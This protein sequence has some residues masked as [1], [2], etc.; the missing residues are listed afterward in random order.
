MSN[1]PQLDK[2]AL[3]QD[4]LEQIKTSQSLRRCPKCSGELG[5]AMCVAGD[6]VSAWQN[7]STSAKRF[8]F[9]SCSGCLITWSLELFDWEDERGDGMVTDMGRRLTL[10]AYANCAC[11]TALLTEVSGGRYY[12]YGLILTNKSRLA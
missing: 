7:E 12:D 11:R 8:L 10:R 1:H 6:R 5:P 4:V 3:Q 2:N 9:Q